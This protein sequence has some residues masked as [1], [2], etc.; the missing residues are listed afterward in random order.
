[1][2]IPGTTLR[3]R[4]VGLG[5]ADL[6]IRQ[7]EAAAHRL[8]DHFT[9]AGGNLLDTARIYSDW[10]PGEIGRSERI[11]GDWLQRRGR[12]DDL[13]ITTKGGHPPLQAM[14]R[15]RL[16][17]ASLR[18]DIDASLRALRC[19]VIDLYWLHRDDPARPVEDII[20]TLAG[21]HRAGKARWFGASNWTSA[22]IAS[23]NVHAAEAGL[24]GFV[25]SQPLWC[26]GTAAM[27]PRDDRSL[28]ALTPTELA[29]TRALPIALLPYSAQ[30][31]GF[32]SKLLTPGWS[33]PAH[34]P[35]NT[36][37]NQALVPLIRE[38]CAAHACTPNAVVL[39]YLI[40]Q[41]VP[42]LPIVGC[43][44]PTQIDCT[45]ADLGVTLTAVELSRLT[46]KNHETRHQPR[47]QE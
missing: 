14:E 29:A 12:R 46:P 20:A 31:G 6:G 36:P 2:T 25:A 30:A 1:M 34:H 35:F 18:A 44:T 40:S 19:E 13:I 5:A 42:V 17:S 47:P 27:H 11:I 7:D 3:P 15:S 22:R 10:V 16:D 26:L 45:L 37:A 32:F 39:A 21:L 23:A 8:L 43:H 41:D 9:A 38:L 33:A 28:V 24:P 4:L